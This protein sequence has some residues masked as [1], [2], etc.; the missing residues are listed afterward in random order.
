[1]SG[2]L[3]LGQSSSDGH[4]V[5]LEFEDGNF[6]VRLRCPESGCAPATACGQCGRAFEDTEAKRCYDCPDEPPKGCW[7]QSWDDNLAEFV[8]GEIEVPV[9]VTWDGEG[10]LVELDPLLLSPESDSGP[11]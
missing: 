2:Q 7:I 1:M 11:S 4:R 8:T 3:D 5:V 6:Y 9:R 10:P